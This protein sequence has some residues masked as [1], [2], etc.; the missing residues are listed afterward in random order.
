M[1]SQSIL[2]HGNSQ[3][4]RLTKKPPASHSH[5]SSFS[6]DGRID[7]QSLQSKRSS[8]SLRRTPSAP[9]SRTP[10]SNASD[11]LSPRFPA[12]AA[13]AASASANRPNYSPTL[14]ENGLNSPIASQPLAHSFSTSL[15]NRKTKDVPHDNRNNSYNHHNNTTNTIVTPNPAVPDSFPASAFSDTK[16]P[17]GRPLSSKTSEEFIGA[18]FDGTAILN[19]IEATKSPTNVQH[20]HRPAPAPPLRTT[21]DDTRIMGPPP[22]RSSASY[23]AGAESSPISEK[24]TIS[25]TES[26]TSGSKRY[27]DEARENKMAGV[28]RKKSGFSGFMNSLVGSP[29]KPLI[30]APENPVH[31]THVGYDSNTG[32]FTVRLSTPLTLPCTITN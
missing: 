25:K 14:P 15:A 24:P 12:A 27:S 29:K 3:R 11:N 22:L 8:A 4:R 31:V 2:S 26:S 6:I 5:S 20:A 9:P 13:A 16:T 1:D 19:R 30:S 10:T 17:L 23:A 18:P 32:T 7:A 28:L 21:A